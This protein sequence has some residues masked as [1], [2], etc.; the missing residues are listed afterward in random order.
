MF[1]SGVP[2]A[3]KPT[4][5]KF[6]LLSNAPSDET[7]SSSPTPTDSPPRATYPDAWQ[8]YK[9]YL[10]STSILIPIPPGVYRPLPR[11]VKRT[12]LMDWGIYRFDEGRD[13][14]AALEEVRE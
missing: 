4:A 1:A 11:W 2:T 6:F 7:S 12:V 3:E 5:K 13:G 10:D 14:K 8:K 9:T